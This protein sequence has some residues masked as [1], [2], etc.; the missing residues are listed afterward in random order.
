VVGRLWA[1]QQFCDRR[2]EIVGD[3][4]ADTAIGKFDDGVFGAIGVGTSFQDVAVDADVAEL[5]D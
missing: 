1:R 5:V 2:R 3:G 4:A